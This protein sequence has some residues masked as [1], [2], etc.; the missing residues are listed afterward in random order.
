[1]RLLTGD[2]RLLLQ[3]LKEQ[4]EKDPSIEV[5]A[6]AFEIPSTLNTRVFKKNT[7]PELMYAKYSKGRY[8]EI[9]V[10]RR[11]PRGGVYKTRAR[12]L[13]IF[14]NEEECKTYYEELVLRNMKNREGEIKSAVDSYEILMGKMRELIDNE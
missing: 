6:C 4:G 1:M 2:L 13:N 14:D 10:E 11:G 8:R 12:N 7:K 3:E 5:W 9:I